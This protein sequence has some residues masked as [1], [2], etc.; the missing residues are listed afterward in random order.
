MTRQVVHIIKNKSCD[1]MYHFPKG[2]FLAGSR[3]SDNR[4][5]INEVNELKEQLIA[6]KR[7]VKNKHG[8][9]VKKNIKVGLLMAYNLFSDSEKTEIDDLSTHIALF[10]HYPGLI[11][12]F[13]GGVV[14]TNDELFINLNRYCFKLDT[15]SK[16][17]LNYEFLRGTEPNV[18]SKTERFVA[19]LLMKHKIISRNYRHGNAE[20]DECDIVDE[21]LGKQIEVTFALKTELSNRRKNP[22]Y[23]FERI[24][25]EFNDNRFIHPSKSLIKKMSKTYSSKY[26]SYLAVLMIGSPDSSY[27]LFERLVDNLLKESIQKVPFCNYFMICYDPIKDMI[28]V[29]F[30]LENKLITDNECGDFDFIEKETTTYSEINDDSKYLFV[31]RDIFTSEIQLSILEKNHFSDFA[32]KIKVFF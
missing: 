8:L 2:L 20:K 30:P 9:F 6:A 11:D 16:F 21:T 23:D 31:L 12:I 28:Y 13:P 4:H 27:T 3:V 32:K 15:V 14:S 7:I 25:A 24:V 22:I 18:F 19:E 26:Q 29:Y 10:K 17:R 5:P 1:F